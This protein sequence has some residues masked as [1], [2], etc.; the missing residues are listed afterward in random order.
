MND[1]ETDGWMTDRETDGWMH[2][3]RIRP[4]Y[5]P[6]NRPTDEKTERQTDG[7]MKTERER[8]NELVN[9][10]FKQIKN[11]SS[12]SLLLTSERY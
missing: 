1:R 10:T 11:W 5:P 7:D 4:T 3:P 8:T 6:T 9:F 2:G 12:N